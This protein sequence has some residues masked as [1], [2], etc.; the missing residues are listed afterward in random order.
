VADDFS[1]CEQPDELIELAWNAGVDKKT[2]IREGSDAAGLLLAGE[3]R[4]LVTL[5]W[6]FPRPLEAVDRWSENSRSAVAAKLRP[7][8]S[9]V[10]PGCVLGFLVSR[11][12]VAPRTWEDPGLSVLVWTIVASIV[13]LGLVFKVLIDVT[14]RRRA[15]RLDEQRALSVVLDE[16]RR[17]MAVS[18]ALVPRAVTWIRRA[19]AR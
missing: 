6:P 17:G 16:L 13:V 19:L 10:M 11:L 2:L 1:K 12:F 5:F 8:A 3:R 15:A 7:F 4:E 9:A 18:P 14:L